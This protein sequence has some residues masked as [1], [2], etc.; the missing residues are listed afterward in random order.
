MDS[1]GTGYGGQL[2]DLW[3]FEPGQGTSGE[4]TWMG[5]SKIT[6]PS[7]TYGANGASGIY[8]TLGVAAASNQ[9][10][11]REQVASWKDASG[12]IWVFGG[13]GID[14]GGVTG[15]LND[16]WKFDP[17]QGTNGEW[18]WMGG[19]QSVGL[20]FS[21][22][23]GVYGTMGTSSPNNVPGGRYGAVTWVDS[24]GNFWLF[25]G[26]GVDSAGTFGY[27]NDLW[28]YTPG[29]N[30]TP[31]QW[32]W[33]GGTDTVG[34]GGSGTSGVYGTLGVPSAANYPGARDA[35]ASWVDA[36]GNV[37]IFGG[38]GVDSTGTQ[39]YL[40]DLWEYT[41]GSN[42]AAGTW[43]WMGG[44][45]ILQ[46]SNSGAS[47]VPG[48]LGTA[49][50]T[51]VPGGRFSAVTWVDKSGKFWL[52]GGQG[53][54]SIGSSGQ[55]NGLWMFDPTLGAT[56]EWTWMGGDTKVG[57]SGGQTGI[58]GTQGTPDA[59]NVPGGR[60]GMAGWT[61]GSGNLWLFGGQGY[62]SQGNNGNLNDLWEYQP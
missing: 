61:D 4:W 37:W 30:E 47:G 31:G 35:A 20:P 41:P 26:D 39:G 27:L 21:G 33:M 16:L 55:L 14:A 19:G 2:N 40:N 62:D 3:K 49:S 10:G 23:S 17:S 5:G 36:A 11:G 44:S 12:D 25:G 22:P 42:G 34:N 56:G 51:T 45:N 15:E 53:I 54:D 18:T 57:R 60:F 24:S 59:A 29:P 38:L 28:K 32:T 6:T 48:T 50:S 46:A 7:T 13:E 9:P 43:A 58:Y 1:T 52:F 8:G